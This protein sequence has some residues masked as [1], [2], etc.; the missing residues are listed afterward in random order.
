GDR[1]ERET[2]QHFPLFEVLI[3]RTLRA[4]MARPTVGLRADFCGMAASLA[5]IRLFHRVRNDGVDVRW[6]VQT[7][8]EYLL[9][10]ARSVFDLL[11]EIIAAHWASIEVAGQ[12]H[13][14]QLPGSFGDVVRQG[15]RPRT[16]KEIEEKYSLITPL[17]EWYAAQAPLF[18]ILR[19]L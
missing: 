6:F 3:Q 18:L 17:A 7:E 1:P 2:D 8:L 9:M 19:A 12:R 13:K 5:K 10:V 16:A 11:Q 14:R 4:D 15:D